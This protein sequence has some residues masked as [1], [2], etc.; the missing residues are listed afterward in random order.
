MTEPISNIAL[1]ARLPYGTVQKASHILKSFDP[2][3]IGTENLQDCLATQLEL[4]GQS[5]S[6]ATKI[7]REYFDLLVRRRVLELKRKTGAN[8]EDIQTAIEVISNLEPAPGK[9]FSEDSN[10]VVEPD[11]SVYQDEYEEWQIVLNNDYIPKLR[12]S[13]VYLSLIHI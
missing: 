1:N 3:G 13:S 12:I 8:P 7:L 11:V 5:N 2:A 6:L 4:R 10:T 9:R